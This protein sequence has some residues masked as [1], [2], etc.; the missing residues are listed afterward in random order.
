MCYDCL[1]EDAIHDAREELN[2]SASEPR[3]HEF[4]Y[5]CKLEELPANG[6]RGKVVVAEHDEIAIF[7]IKE[8]IYAISN[9]CPHQ[10]TPLLAEGYVDKEALTVE[11]PMHG[12]RYHIDTGKSV[13]GGAGVKS[14]VTRVADGVVWVEEPTPAAPVKLE[15]DGDNY[16]S[17]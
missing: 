8:K 2:A 7:K 1:D 10:S 15:W 4:I 3:A 12:W 16:L 17:D 9:I 11:C 14:Y 5:G 6:K 13:G